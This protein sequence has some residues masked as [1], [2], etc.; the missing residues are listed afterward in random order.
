MVLV[1]GGTGLVGSH[2]LYELS[3]SP[4]KIRA[5]Y[6]NPEKRSM[7]RKLF[8]YYSK[9][10]PHRFDDIEWVQCD[11]LDVLDL[12]DALV[13]IDMVYH[14]AALVSFHR[15]DFQRLIKV[16]RE[17]TTNLVNLCLE[18]KIKKFGHISS[19]AAIGGTEGFLVTEQTKWKVSPRTSGYAISKYGAEREVW[20]ASEEGMDVVI[21]NPSVIVGAGDWN[22]SSLTIFR[23]VA[24]GLKFY[25][26][27]QNAFVDARDVARIFVHLMQSDWKNERFLCV[28]ENV[29]FRTFL[30]MIAQNLG[31]K[32]PTIS[33]PYWLMGLTWRIAG[34]V[35]FLTGSKPTI[36]KETAK[37][38]FSTMEYSNAKIRDAIDY[39][40][41][42]VQD[43]IQNAISGRLDK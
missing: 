17:G 20:R 35:A 1:T 38:A 22:E 18:H 43:A 25:T 12:Q 33:T 29:P 8:D 14:C 28:S 9:G 26:P 36:T 16:N 21:L 10:A 27:G 24:K 2:L 31:K 30:Q 6:R 37:S 32:G 11:I 13:G 7:V 40:F 19:T 41:I 42:P 3:Q 4:V 5:T 23:S 39:T 15:G 34:F